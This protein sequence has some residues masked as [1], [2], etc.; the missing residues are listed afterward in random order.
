MWTLHSTSIWFSY[1]LFSFSLSTLAK[2][3]DFSALWVLFYWSFLRWLAYRTSDIESLFQY[4]QVLLRF[5]KV[6]LFTIHNLFTTKFTKTHIIKYK[7]YYIKLHYTLYKTSR[8]ERWNKLIADWVQ[9]I[10]CHKICVQSEARTQMGSWTS[11]LK[12]SSQGLFQPD[13]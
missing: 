11:P 7:N 6:T 12:V 1:S 10:Q 3:L 4:A 13:L 8:K 2:F 5:S 9:K